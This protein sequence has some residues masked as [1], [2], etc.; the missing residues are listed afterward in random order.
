LL[1]SQP[2]G[3]SRLTEITLYEALKGD[4]G[5][6]LLKD[7]TNYVIVFSESEP[8][9]GELVARFYMESS[10]HDIVLIGQPVWQIWKTLELSFLHKLQL[11]L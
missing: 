8:D 11:T 1:E 9:V 5:N 6:I 7:Q 4:L 10:K 3:Q 2:G